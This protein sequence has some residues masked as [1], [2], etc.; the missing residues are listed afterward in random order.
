MTRNLT[1]NYGLRWEYY[2]IF[3]HNWYGATRFDPATDN[4]LIGG[5]GGVPWDTGATATKKNFAPRVGLAYRLGSKTVIRSGYGIT[6]DP[7]NMRNQRNAYPSVINQDYTPASTYQ[8]ITNAGVPQTSLAHRHPGAIVP[9]HHGRHHQTIQH[10][11]SDNLPADHRSLGDISAK[12]ESRL[13]PELEPVY[14]A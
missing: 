8:F 2:P 3:S 9:G 4:I 14:P 12:H 7:D 13:H 6:V 1:L 11:I 5:E 10:R